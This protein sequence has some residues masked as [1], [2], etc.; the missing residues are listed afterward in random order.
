MWAKAVGMFATRRFFVAA[1]FLALCIRLVWA[2]D[3]GD[4]QRFWD[5]DSYIRIADNVIAGDGF[6]WGDQRVGRPPLYPLLVAATRYRMMDREFLALYIVQAVLGTAAALLFSLAARRLM[7][8]VAGGI[9]AL[10]LA[11]YPFLVY[12]TGAVLSETL[13]VFLL[14]AFF[15]CLVACFSRPGILRAILAG[16]FGGAAFLTRPS[17]LGLLV[18]FAIVLIVSVR[19]F[20]RGLLVAGV[21]LTWWPC[22]GR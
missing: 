21:M 13:F 19:P 5:A 14:A 16:A 15:Y 10:W 12:Y 20:L 4:Q 22:R 1:A 7:G 3:A 18:L 9:T 2:W 17:I 6:V 8:R 11:F